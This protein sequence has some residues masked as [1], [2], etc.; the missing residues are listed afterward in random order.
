MMEDGWARVRAERMCLASEG[1]VD[2]KNKGGR[3]GRGRANVK[4][5]KRGREEGLRGVDSKYK[6]PT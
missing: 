1:G 6:S 5:S 4:L 2:D 3:T